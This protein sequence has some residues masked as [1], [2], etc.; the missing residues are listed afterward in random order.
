MIVLERFF[1]HLFYVMYLQ[2]VKI[3]PHFPLHVMRV[4]FFQVT[5]QTALYFLYDVLR[6]SKHTQSLPCLI[7][8]K[9]QRN[10]DKKTQNV[11]KYHVFGQNKNYKEQ[12]SQ[13]VT[14]ILSPPVSHCLLRVHL[15]VT[16]VMFFNNFVNVLYC[17]FKVLSSADW[18][19]LFWELFVWK[20]HRVFVT[21]NE[22]NIFII[23]C[24]LL[25]NTSHVLIHVSSYQ[26]IYPTIVGSLWV[27]LRF[28]MT[29]GQSDV[30]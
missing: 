1:L 17:L 24:L 20:T 26:N 10:Y 18:G 27:F 28:Q 19:K 7:H 15:F 2:P 14:Q 13:K 23:F 29:F 22:D 6:W 30:T 5:L 25:N 3:L 21:R 12:H 4:Y 9:Y 8:I 16:N 11:N